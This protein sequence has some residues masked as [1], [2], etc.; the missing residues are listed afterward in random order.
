MSRWEKYK[1]M[2]DA[3]FRDLC[4]VFSEPMGEISK[5]SNIRLQLKNMCV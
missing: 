3:E 5:I 2:Q 4:M 1:N